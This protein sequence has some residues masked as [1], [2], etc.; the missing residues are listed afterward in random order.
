VS[1]KALKFLPA[2]VWFV[3]S[4]ILFTIPP[5]ELPNEAIFKIPQQDKIIHIFIFFFL[6]YL[7]CRPFK[8]SAFPKKKITSWFFSI[9][10]Y[11]LAYGI[12]VE[13]IQKYFV[14]NRSYEVWDIV[15]DAIG[16]FI[17][18]FY[19]RKYFIK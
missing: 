8:L 14:P 12:S 5:P 9:A 4:F 2:I 15:A 11:G 18:Y 6:V 13:F 16:C 3:I 19:C 17:G 7:F 10:L 1:I